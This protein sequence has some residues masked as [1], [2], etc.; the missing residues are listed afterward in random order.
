MSF[1]FIDGTPNYV[2]WLNLVKIGHCEVPERSRGLPNKKNSG[3]AGLVPAP[4]LAKMGR[5][6]PQ[7]PER[8][9]P[10]TCPR[11]PN[12]V[13]IGCV[14]PDLFPKDWLFG[15]KSQYD[16]IGFEWVSSC[17]TA[18]Q[19]K[20]TKRLFSAIQGLY[21]GQDMNITYKKVKPM[22]VRSRLWS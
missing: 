4:I 13:R 15:S 17:L 2:S 10:L 18:H 20:S 16:N 5:S 11:V 1:G 19:H 21:D 12:L 3:S 14:L 8:C 6:R 22:N 9:H 7:F